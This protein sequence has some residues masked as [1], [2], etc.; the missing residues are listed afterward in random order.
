MINTKLTACSKT[1]YFLKTV[2]IA[3]IIPHLVIELNTVIE[4]EILKLLSACNYGIQFSE[5]A[6]KL[7]PTSTRPAVWTDFANDFRRE[8]GCRAH[9]RTL[10]YYL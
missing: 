1:F 7:A 9:V 6:E 4:R 10:H 5:L 8:C 2:K 3:K